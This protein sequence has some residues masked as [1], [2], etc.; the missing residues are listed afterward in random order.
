MSCLR[1]TATDDRKKREKGEKG[2]KGK[3]GKGV[4]K[5][6]KGEKCVKGEKGKGEKKDIVFLHVVIALVS[7]RF[8][9]EAQSVTCAMRH[10]KF[11]GGPHFM[12]DISMVE[13]EITLE[14]TSTGSFQGDRILAVTISFKI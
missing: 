14:N 10:A 7:T 5:G 4:K 8:T 3:K 12:S 1:C 11:S 2:E 13:F 6:T 9:R